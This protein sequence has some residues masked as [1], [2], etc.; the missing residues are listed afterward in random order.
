MIGTGYHPYAK[1]P[2]AAHAFLQEWIANVKVRASEGL[3]KIMVLSA[4]MDE[5]RN[6]T[7][8]DRVVDFIHASG[9]LGHIHDKAAGKNDNFYVGWSAGMVTLAFLAYND[10]CDFIYQEQDCLAFGD[11]VEQLYKDMGEGWAALGRP[12]R[13]MPRMRSTQSL[14]IVRHKRIPEFVRDYLNLGEDINSYQVERG[15]CF[16]EMKFAKMLDM[17][18]MKYRIQSEGWNVD[19][20]RPIPYHLPAFAAQQITSLEYEEMKRRGLL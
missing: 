4:G 7:F 1:T 20:D 9:D 18:L 12:L 19:R 11:Y 14:F 16:G 5:D 17:D 15:G 6:R 2:I 10:N 3:H 13:S 8:N